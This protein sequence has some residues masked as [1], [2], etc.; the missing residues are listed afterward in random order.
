MNTS[1]SISTLGHYYES[2]FPTDSDGKPCAYGDNEKYPYVFFPDIQDIQKVYTARLSE[3]AL[4]CAPKPQTQSS[5]AR[6][7]LRL[8]LAQA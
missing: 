6:P 5:S 2:N 3:Y 1:T 4:A 8:P 7:T